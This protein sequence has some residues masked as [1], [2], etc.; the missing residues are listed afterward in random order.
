MNS[1]IDNILLRLAQAN[2]NSNIHP[3]GPIANSLNLFQERNCVLDTGKYSTFLHR[4]CA[5]FFL[6]VCVCVLVHL[7]TVANFIVHCTVTRIITKE[8]IK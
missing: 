3:H 4:C 1:G 2:K 7:R 8:N 5:Y 6:C